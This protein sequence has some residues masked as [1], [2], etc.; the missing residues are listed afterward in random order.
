MSEWIYIPRNKK[1]S[2]NTDLMNI[3]FCIPYYGKN[4]SHTTI[5]STC[6]SQIRK[7]YPVNPILVCKTSDSYMPSDITY[8]NLKVFNTFVD[9]SHVIGAVELLI[10]ECKTSHFIICHDSMF[11]IKELPKSVLDYR[12]FPLWHFNSH[13]YDFPII[14]CI[15]EDS[16]ITDTEQIAYM[17][18]NEYAI[19]WYGLFGPAFGGQFEVL[20]EF[21]SILNI[22]PININKY[23]GRNGINMCERY[24]SLIFTYMGIDTQK[25]L[26]GDIFKQPSAFKATEIPDFNKLKYENS[27]F[28]K[29]WQGR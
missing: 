19:K 28:Y 14:E 5:L 2:E 8:I 15:K 18:N 24:F 11:L 10:K 6:I 7:Y 26:N 3:T 4:P 17:Y 23:L 16:T 12:I 13:R 29:I 1:K 21:W 25:S 9:S 22:N 20:K 27:Y